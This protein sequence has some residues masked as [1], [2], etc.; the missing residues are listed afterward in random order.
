M[1]VNAGLCMEKL[2]IVGARLVLEADNSVSRPLPGRPWLHPQPP[3]LRRVQHTPEP[4]EA[5]L[6]RVFCRRSLT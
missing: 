3:S 1:S 5:S 6:Y 4:S 2:V